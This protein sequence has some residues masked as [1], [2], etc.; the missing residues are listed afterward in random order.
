MKKGFK[1][2]AG[3]MTL[4]M[5]VAAFAACGGGN[6]KNYAENNTQFKIC[7]SGPLTGD[8]A[9]YGLGVKNGATMAVEEINKVSQAELGFTFKFDMADDRA[10]PT[11]VTS[12]YT[13]FYEGGMQISLGTVTSGACIQWKADAK[14]D[15]IFM[16]TPS[17]TSDAV[18]ANSDYTYQ[19]CFSDNNQGTAAA[20]Y[21][22]DNVTEKTVGVFYQT[23]D[24]YS[25]GIYNTFIA[26]M[27]DKASAV[28][29]ASFTKDTKTDFS[30]QVQTLKD[31]E[32][33]FMP[34]YYSDAS[35]FM[36]TANLAANK[37]EQYYGCDG[38]DGIDSMAGF[39]VTTIPQ[40]ISFLTHFNSNAEGGKAKDF[41]DK[42]TEE[43]GTETLNQF[44][45]SAYDCVYAIYEAL[46]AAKADGKEVKVNMAPKAVCEIMKEQLQKITLTGFVTGTTIKWNKD[47]TV[48][49]PADRV[50]VKGIDK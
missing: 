5:A 9:K 28:V 27:G 40:E 25:S 39:D 30:S 49:K 14:D 8:Y 37:I 22:K 6:D 31:C 48:N 23:D 33:V 50:I 4:T 17:A 11:E 18:Y 38:L 47:G 10:D 34:I 7:T 26:E 42:Y 2:V 20:K 35:R 24:E 1:A 3:A 32:F 46:K 16:L 21:V 19:M 44:G 29:K 13:S 12:K 43:F 45:A 41:V 15:G 36:T